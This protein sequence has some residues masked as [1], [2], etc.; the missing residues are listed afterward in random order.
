MK[1]AIGDIRD[2][3]A[4]QAAI[5]TADP[6]I[7][8]HIAAQA[9]VRRSIAQPAETFAVNVAGTANVLSALRNRAALQAVLVITSDKVYAHDDRQS[10]PFSRG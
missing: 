6:Q 9:L 8:I 2:A 3:G 10:E 1:S 4:L 7:V 5:D